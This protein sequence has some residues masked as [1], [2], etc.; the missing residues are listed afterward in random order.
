MGRIDPVPAERGLGRLLASIDP[1]L[2]AGTLVFCAIEHDGRPSGL[3]VRMEF[4]EHEA[5]TLVVSAEDARTH[6]L[7][8]EFPCEWIVIGARSDLSAVG[9]LAE[10]TARLA[11]AGISANVVS[12]VHHDHLFVPVGLGERAVAVLLELQGRHRHAG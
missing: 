4:R 7:V 1:Q 2:Q 11:T 12:A 6:G 8:G 5:T 3:A 9:F 10:I